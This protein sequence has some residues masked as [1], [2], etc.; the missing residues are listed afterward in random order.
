[1]MAGVENHRTEDRREKGHLDEVGDYQNLRYVG[2][3]EAAWRIY[4]FSMRD[5]KPAV[6]LMPIHLSHEQNVYWEEGMEQEVVENGP[7]DSML[8]SFFKTN[9]EDPSASDLTYQDFPKRYVW[10]KKLKR[11]DLR[12]RNQAFPTIGRLKTVQPSGNRELFYLRMLLH[13]EHCKVIS[14]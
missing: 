11:W 13:N 5:T 12:Q 1:M 6:V 2:S 9:L 7:P 10:N 3:A 8:T 4:G 14:F